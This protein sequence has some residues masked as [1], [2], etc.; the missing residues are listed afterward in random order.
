MTVR[1]ILFAYLHRSLCK[2]MD[3]WMR[4]AGLLR[5]VSDISAYWEY[6]WPRGKET[7]MGRRLVAVMVVLAS[8]TLLW[9]QPQAG[10]RPRVFIGTTLEPAEDM[11][12]IVREL[13]PNSPAAKA[14]I[15][16]GDK[17]VQLEGKEVKDFDQFVRMLNEHKP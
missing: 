7:A 14:G 5:S 13:A 1:G 6:I 16:K 3:V 17:I 15:K 9:S 4:C 10:G 11:G 8:T 2:R 12:L